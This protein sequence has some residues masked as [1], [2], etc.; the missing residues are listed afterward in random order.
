MQLPGA[1]ERKAILF[2]C[3]AD[4][5]FGGICAGGQMEAQWT[6]QEISSYWL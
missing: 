5:A 3:A 1:N 2:L 6:Q 4:F